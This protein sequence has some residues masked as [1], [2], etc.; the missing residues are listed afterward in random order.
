ML[1][2]WVELNKFYKLESYFQCKAFNALCLSLH[3]AL[4][5][6]PKTQSVNETDGEVESHVNDK[7]R[8]D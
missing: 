1:N 7:V 2:R 4:Q 6:I 5:V 3:F 8:E